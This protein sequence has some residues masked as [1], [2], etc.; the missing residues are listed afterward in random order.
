MNP[1][2]LL[3]VLLLL[4]VSLRLLEIRSKIGLFTTYDKPSWE[5]GARV[6]YTSGFL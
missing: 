1:L 2:H 6:A 5:M 4:L 3:A